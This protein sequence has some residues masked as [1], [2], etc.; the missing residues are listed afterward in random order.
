MVAALVG[1][2]D[3]GHQRRVLGT[4]GLALARSGRVDEAAE[5][6]AE[7]R[8]TVVRAP[9]GVRP[10][11]EAGAAGR[12]AGGGPVRAERGDLRVDR[13]ARGAAAG[14]PGVAAEWFA[15]AAAAGDAGQDLRDVAEALVGLAASSGSAGRVSGWRR[16]AGAAGSGCC[17]TTERLL[18]WGGLRG[19]PRGDR[20]GQGSSTCRPCG[21]P[22]RERLPCGRGVWRERTSPRLNPSL[23]SARAGTPR[24]SPAR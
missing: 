7:L 10:G 22:G 17:R 5:V 24:R 8:A 12:P 21:Q 3:P 11:M 23:S 2:G 13:G 18:A 19:L 4:V 15:V 1:V 6:L 16:C 20:P 9:S 14:G